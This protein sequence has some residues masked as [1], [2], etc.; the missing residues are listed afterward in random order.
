MPCTSGSKSNR[1][2]NF[3]GQ[4]GTNDTH[5]SRLDPD[6]Q[7][8]RKSKH[9]EAL[10]S[11]MGHALMENRN[12]LVVDHRLTRATGKAERE[13]GIEM[14]AVRPGETRKTVG[15]DKGDD[16]VTSSPSAA[17]SG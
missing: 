10:P 9:A 2:V 1:E 4:P 11:Y 6:S 12:G 16:T 15:A 13:A 7:L 8:Y 3:C 14:L 5:E 17:L